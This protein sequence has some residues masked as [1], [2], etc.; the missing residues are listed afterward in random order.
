[1]LR[2]TASGEISVRFR[3]GDSIDVWPTPVAP[4]AF[5]SRNKPVAMP[6]I[7]DGRTH[8]AY[9]KIGSRRKGWAHLEIHC[10]ISRKVSPGRDGLRGRVT[11]S[12]PTYVLFSASSFRGAALCRWGEYRPYGGNP[13]A[14]D[15][16]A[17]DHSVRARVLKIF[18]PPS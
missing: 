9:L 16:R 15:R 17:E 1:M 3:F 14:E 2:F 18:S 8:R 7:R 11:H 12:S 10:A 6:W 13:A 4:S 5:P